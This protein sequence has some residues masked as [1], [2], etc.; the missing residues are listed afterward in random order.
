M[1]RDLN[2]ITR[3]CERAVVTA[4]RAQREAGTNDVL[5]FRNCAS[6]YRYHHPEASEAEAAHST[7]VRPNSISTEPAAWSSQL[8]VIVIG[9]SSSLARPSARVVVMPLTLTAVTTA[10]G[11][12]LGAGPRRGVACSNAR[13]PT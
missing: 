3:R 7:L 10:R 1:G 13:P 6:L 9:R 8:R 5:A 12:R 2:H 11:G 4:Y